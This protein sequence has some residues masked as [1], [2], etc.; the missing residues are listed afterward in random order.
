MNISRN[1]IIGHKRNGTFVYYIQVQN[2][3][4]S[5]FLEMSSRNTLIKLST[6]TSL[7]QD[8][9]ASQ[10]LSPQLKQNLEKDPELTSLQYKHNLLRVQLISKYYQL[11]KNRKTNLYKNFKKVQNKIRAKKKKILYICKK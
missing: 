9:S 2:N 1:I 6:N 4:Q 7:T 3:T 11:Y 10:K 5:T 8:A